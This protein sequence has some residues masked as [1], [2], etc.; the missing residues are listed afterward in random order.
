MVKII[1]SLKKV[2]LINGMQEEETETQTRYIYQYLQR[3]TVSTL[4]FFQTEILLLIL[5]YQ[6]E[7]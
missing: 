1:Q 7:K 4:G 5:N 6:T 3:Y 2:D